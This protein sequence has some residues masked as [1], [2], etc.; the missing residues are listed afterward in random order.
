VKLLKLLFRYKNLRKLSDFQRNENS[1]V[2][3]LWRS[4]IFATIG[5]QLSRQSDYNWLEFQV[6]ELIKQ[7]NL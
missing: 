1:L 4:E 3:S 7:V 2:L 5:H 6:Q